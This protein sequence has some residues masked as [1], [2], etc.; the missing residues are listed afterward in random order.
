MGITSGQR[1]LCLELLQQLAY[2]TS[3]D[4]YQDIYERF[5]ECAP[6]TVISYF[7]KQW[8]PIRSQWVMGMKYKSG[9]FLNG[10]NKRLE[11][12][13]QKL[14]SVITRYS[15]LEEFIDKFFL[16]L[17]ELRSE[18]DH[19]AALVTQKVPVACY[20]L[21]DDVSLSYMKYLTLYAY[22]FF[23]NRWN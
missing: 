14:K 18:H 23:A 7:D 21:T 8:H 9:N 17:R 11:C 4:N 12:I 13:N 2:A 15:S 22:Q 16:I 5:C 1:N 10:I 6:P 20:A 3:E 19:K